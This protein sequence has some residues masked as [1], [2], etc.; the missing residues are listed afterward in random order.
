MDDPLLTAIAGELRAHGIDHPQAVLDV[1]AVAVRILGR[2]RCVCRR[3]V[4]QAHHLTFVPGCLWCSTPA[5]AVP[6][7]GKS[8]TET[9]P[10]GGLL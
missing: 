8:R 2:D 3:P 9:V 4:H 6:K 10:T 1:A 5:G 7:T